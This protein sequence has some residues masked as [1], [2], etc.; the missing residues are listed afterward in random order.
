MSTATRR[1]IVASHGRSSRSGVER[2][3]RAPRYA[4]APGAQAMLT[5]AKPYACAS[6]IASASSAS[7]AS[8]G[9]Q[10]LPNVGPAATTAAISDQRWS[11]HGNCGGR[12]EAQPRGAVR[13]SAAVRQAAQHRR[14]R[15][16]EGGGDEECSADRDGPGPS[17]SRRSGAS[18]PSTPKR[19][20]GSATNQALRRIALPEGPKSRRR[21]R[22]PGVRAGVAGG[23]GEHGGEDGDDR[24]GELRADRRRRGAEQRAEQRAHD[25]RRHGGADRLAA[26]VGRRG[27]TSHARPAAHA[28]ELA[29]P[30]AKRA[31][32]ST[33]IE[34][35]KP[36]VMVVTAIPVRPTSTVG[37][38]PKRTL[39]NP[40]G[41]RDEHAERVRGGEQPGSG[42]RQPEL[43]RVVGSSG[44]SA[45]KNIVSTSTMAATRAKSSL[46]TRYQ[47]GRR[48]S[49]KARKPS[50]PSSLVR[51]SAIRC[52]V[53][54]AS[55]GASRTSRLAA[56]AARGPALRSSRT[57]LHR[58]VEIVRDLVDEPDAQRGRGVETLTGDEV[59]PRGARA[60]LRQRE[61]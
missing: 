29:S 22:S 51:R 34:S 61:R 50:W 11:S 40:A 48:R 36:N 43:V 45:A 28:N 57:A 12:G 44:V 3:R 60:D 46:R 39:A 30:W 54:C 59:A 8:A 55:S 1:V 15:R 58:A 31:V 49:R 14:E 26:A 42:L 33:Q 2:L 24:E 53:S 35:P 5:S 19:R 6:P 38:T 21:L 16:F 17:S 20:A 47:P 7:W 4:A 56:R 52:A 32:S 10:K 27:G 37:L 23:D 25:R 18:T 41:S 13:S 9:A